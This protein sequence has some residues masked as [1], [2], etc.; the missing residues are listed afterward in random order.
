MWLQRLPK[1]IGELAA[2]ANL[3]EMRSS[4]PN[5]VSRRLVPLST[6]VLGE[7]GEP[8]MLGGLLRWS[9]LDDVF[10]FYKLA[11]EDGSI[12]RSTQFVMNCGARFSVGA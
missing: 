9:R 1:I 11:R 7:T 5:R 6:V 8:L 4:L 3:T 2:L 10:P 12:E